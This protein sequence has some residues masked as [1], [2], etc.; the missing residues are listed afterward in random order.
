M[1]VG[2]AAIKLH[3]LPVG[4]AAIKLHTM[5]VGY[6]GKLR[7]SGLQMQAVTL[8]MQKMESCLAH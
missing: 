1:P 8:K 2:S 6:A 5:P 4:Y 3:N 7:L